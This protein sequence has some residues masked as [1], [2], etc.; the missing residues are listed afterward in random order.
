MLKLNIYKSFLGVSIV[1]QGVKNP[2]SIHEDKGSTPGLAQWIKDPALPQAVA[3]V[4]DAA[5]IPHC[6]GCGVGWQLQL[7]FDP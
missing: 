4:P 2:T 1:A 6:C 7:W 5:W 3:Q